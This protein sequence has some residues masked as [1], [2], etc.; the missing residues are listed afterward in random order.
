MKLR[1]VEI[2]RFKKDVRISTSDF[3]YPTEKEIFRLVRK[4]NITHIGYIEG[5]L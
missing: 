3:K 1:K 2:V 5:L 4:Q